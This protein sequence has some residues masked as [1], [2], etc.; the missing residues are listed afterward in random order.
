M[1]RG[2]VTAWVQRTAFHTVL[3]DLA[4]SSDPVL[5]HC[6]AGK[7]RTGWTSVILQ[8]IAGVSSATIM[9]DYLA[10]KAYT[11]DPFAVSE[12]WLQAATRE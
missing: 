3:F 11:G 6:S 5:Y 7:D 8:S 4:N 9:Q 12:S 1:Y 10:S 2:F